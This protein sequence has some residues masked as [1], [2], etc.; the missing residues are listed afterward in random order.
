M[1]QRCQECKED[2]SLA[3]SPHTN[4]GVVFNGVNVDPPTYQIPRT[5][6]VQYIEG[7]Q[8]TSSAMDAASHLRRL[9]ENNKD[10]IKL[11]DVGRRT[12]R[13]GNAVAALCATRPTNQGSCLCF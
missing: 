10:V 4:F 5:N 3:A 11:V 13:F 12:R 6:D 1:E 7:T 2:E 8:T 9:V